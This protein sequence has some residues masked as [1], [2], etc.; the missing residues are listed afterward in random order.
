[1]SLK[2]VY[3]QLCYP[4]KVVPGQPGFPD[5]VVPG[6]LG[7]S[8]NFATLT[9]QYQDRVLPGQLDYTEKVVPGYLDKMYTWTR[10]SPGQDRYLGSH[11]SRTLTYGQGRPIFRSF[12]CIM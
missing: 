5:K 8:D 12:V 7:Y 11:F 4:D 9:Q 1:M 10:C 3:G 2:L 6:K